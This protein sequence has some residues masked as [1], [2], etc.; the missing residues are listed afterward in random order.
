MRLVLLCTRP[1]FPQ[2]FAVT[3]SRTTLRCGDSGFPRKQDRVAR[4]RLADLPES[5]PK[6][7]CS[8]GAEPF[9][10]GWFR[11]DLFLTVHVPLLLLALL[12]IA[13]RASDADIEICRWFY[14]PGAQ[15][16][17]G[18]H[19]PLLQWIYDYGPAPALAL[20]IGGLA[21]GSL[22]L[23]WQRLE[24]YREAG[25]FLAAL[26]A[27]GPGLIV[28][29][30][31]KPHWHR[32]RPVQTLAFGGSEPFVPVWNLGAS[33]QSRSF[34]SG[35]ASMGF[36]LLAPAF[37]LYRRWR[38]VLAFTAL[39]LVGGLVIGMG[40]IMQGAHYP[41]DVVWSGG[42]VYLSGLV[43]LGM[44]QLVK[45]AAQRARQ[46]DEPLPEEV[47]IP[48][49][50]PALEEARDIASTETAPTRRAA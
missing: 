9:L 24:P 31:F 32:P 6:R 49:P 33:P 5:E 15:T 28:N 40:R 7:G 38:W 27:L 39:G 4:C 43:V 3:E 46:L 34:P 35:H 10:K 29:G 44:F 19:S 13:F 48:F 18:K 2:G 42:M 12:T 45:S 25:F 36:Y 22:S 26:L 47:V 41:S 50:S 11:P 14:L 30:V 23:V 37:L 21:I 20:G 8:T 1:V 17:L 16:W